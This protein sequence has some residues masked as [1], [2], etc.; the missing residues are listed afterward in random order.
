MTVK[1]LDHVNIHTAD[2]AATIDFYVDVIGLSQGD[3]PTTIGRP[4]AWLY[5]NGRPLIHLNE[6]EQSRHSDTGAIDHVAFET[7]GYD[8]VAGKLTRRGVPF[9]AKE[10]ADFRIRQIFVHDPNGVKLEL[11]FRDGQGQSQSQS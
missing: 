5:C 7:E 9:Q 6:V 4:G 11:N 10:L 3:R 8:D 1:L 2:L